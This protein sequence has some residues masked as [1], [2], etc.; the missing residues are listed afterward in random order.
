[1]ILDIL[2]FSFTVS[3]L[4][5]SIVW[6][7]RVLGF[8]LVHRQLQDNPYTR[9]IIGMDA[10]IETAFLRLPGVPSHHSTHVLE[11]IQYR[12]HE[13]DV[14]DLRTSTVGTAHIA[15]MV[16]D[17]H[18]RFGRLRALG[19]EFR[20]EVPVE[21]TE[22]ANAGGFSV[23]LSDPDGITFELMQPS[24]RRLAELGIAR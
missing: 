8:E 10:V 16:D 11:L 4:D 7:E 21:M 17:I 3:E 22:G 20:S 9:E 19:V 12:G 13:T 23:Y 15:F 6:Y 5:R 1:V 18:E 14:G 24:P 2:H